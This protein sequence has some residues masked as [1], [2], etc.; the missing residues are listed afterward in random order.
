MAGADEQRD[1]LSG[2][3]LGSG[4]GVSGPAAFATS[5]PASPGRRRFL[6]AGLAGAAALGLGGVLAWHGAGYAVP[7]EVAARLRAL[8]P[9]EYLV[10]AA[11]ARRLLRDDPAAGAP[12][13][14]RD[15]TVAAATP[16][17]GA[18]SPSPTRPSP[19][20]AVFPSPDDVGVALFADGL[21]ARLD[22]A[23]RRDLRRLLHVLEH[24]LPVAAG[25]LGRFSRLDGDGQDAVLAAMAESPVGLLRGAFVTLKGLCALAYF[26]DARTWAAIGYD[27]PLLGRPPEGWAAAALA[28]PE[29]RAG[30]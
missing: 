6:R 13:P 2:S 30:R 7:P 23:T 14:T 25:R 26:R 8:S 16:R 9:K 10:L 22:S 24:A 15:V 20:E 1:L 27:G 12:R 28:R 17:D 3:A 19:D 21:I 4:D 11:F 5:R 18:S 29:A